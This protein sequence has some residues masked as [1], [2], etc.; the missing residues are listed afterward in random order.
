MTHVPV[1]RVT[2]RALAFG[3][4]LV[5]AAC[6]FGG[7]V[8]LA[9]TGSTTATTAADPELSVSIEPGDDYSAAVLELGFYGIANAGADPYFSAGAAA[10]REQLAVY[11]ARAVG[12]QDGPTLAFGDVGAASWGYKKIGPVCDAGL[13]QGT[14]SGT[15]SPDVP[16]SRQEAASAI[17]AALRYKSERSGTDLGVSLEA[18][19]VSDWLGGFQDRDLI[20]YQYSSG[21]AVAYRLGLFDDPADGWLLPRLGMSHQELLVMLYRA[22]A[23]PLVSKSATPAMVPA[24]DSYPDLSKGAKGSLVL[25]LQERLNTMTYFTG[26]PDG[27]YSSQTRDA[28]YAFQKY[29]R[30]KRTGVVD[31]TVWDAFWTATNPVPVYVG[32]YGKRVEVDLTRQV[33][34]LITDNKVVMTVHVSTGRYGTPTGNWRTRTLSHG[35]RPTSLGPIYS[36]SYFMPKNA[37]HGYPSVPLYPAS[38]GCV[39]T[40]IWI[41]DEVVDEL[42]MDELV[43]VFY[44]K[45][46]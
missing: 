42:V 15:F 23:L 43:H 22:F 13:M 12:L 30:M 11:L 34:M 9:E 20:G 29:Q 26:K 44:N 38:H 46:D 25:L 24:V 36:P 8:A 1:C 14:S 31:G 40:P 16:V 27:K 32:D 2:R 4:G 35:W 45:A 39:R 6:L 3:A 41:Q 17:V 7:A 21:V 5:V 10:T 18:S 33:M 37:I 19:Q 28:V